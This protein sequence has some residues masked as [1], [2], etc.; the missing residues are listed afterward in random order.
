MVFRF[1]IGFFLPYKTNHALTRRFSNAIRGR[2]FRRLKP[3]SNRRTDSWK[4]SLSA[5][6]TSPVSPALR[7]GSSKIL[8]LLK[9]VNV[10]D[11]NKNKN[12][13]RTNENQ[14]DRDSNGSFISSFQCGPN[15]QRTRISD[16]QRRRPSSAP[17]RTASLRYAHHPLSRRRHRRLFP[18]SASFLSPASF[19]SPFSAPMASPRQRSRERTIMTNKHSCSCL[20]QYPIPPL[21]Q[22]TSLFQLLFLC[23]SAASIFL[24]LLFSRNFLV[25]P[26]LLNA[27]DRQYAFQRDVS[28][29]K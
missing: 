25:F 2:N 4:R 24:H 15:G 27:F 19:S 29:L 8:L 13:E 3:S 16:G 28:T 21:T 6:A 9:K 12:K 20:E 17:K 23:D 11:K 22:V 10:K 1:R 14:R 26:S 7:T 5:A 18:S